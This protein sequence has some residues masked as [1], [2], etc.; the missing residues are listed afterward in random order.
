MA[1]FDPA[2]AAL[3]Q[4]RS[5]R[6]EGRSRLTGPGRGV[7]TSIADVRARAAT[8]LSPNSPTGNGR[9]EVP[10]GYESQTRR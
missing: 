7:T 4:A 1:S 10:A 5:R 9:R 8:I 3:I 6:R 2:W